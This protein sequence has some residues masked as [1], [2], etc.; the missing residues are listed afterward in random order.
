MI[1]I[2]QENEFSSENSLSCHYDISV[3]RETEYDVFACD[4]HSI[5]KER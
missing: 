4:E 5:K 1:R 3:F 2:W